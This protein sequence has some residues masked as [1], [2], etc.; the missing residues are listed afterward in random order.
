[1]QQLENMKTNVIGYNRNH[2]QFLLNFRYS[3]DQTRSRM[4]MFGR[5]WQARTFFYQKY[6]YKT[7]LLHKSH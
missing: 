5:F 6:K 3:L 4:T 7:A 1:M 2:Y